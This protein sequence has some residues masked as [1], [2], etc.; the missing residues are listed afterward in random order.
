MSTLCKG[1]SLITEHRDRKLRTSSKQVSTVYLSMLYNARTVIH[2]RY[3]E[4]IVIHRRIG[5]E[6]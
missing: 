6:G 2:I 1:Y 3:H 5:H 4:H